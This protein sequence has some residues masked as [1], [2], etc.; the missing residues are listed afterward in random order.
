[1][2]R[3]AGEILILLLGVSVAAAGDERRDK[4]ATPAKQYEAL[5]KDFQEAARELYLKAMTDE[6]RIE[7]TARIEKLSPRLLE[8]AEKNPRDPVALDAL[9]QVVRQEL[10]LQENTSHPGRGKDN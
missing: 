7:S 2:S 3:M 1:M 10:W 8:L 6:A 5:A 4:G 9:V